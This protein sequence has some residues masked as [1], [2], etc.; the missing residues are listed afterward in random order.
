MSKYEILNIQVMR[1]KEITTNDELSRNP[2]TGYEKC[3]LKKH[4]KMLMLGLKRSQI[5][6][7]SLTPLC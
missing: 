4:F 3:M 2:G 7:N 6:V 5:S 1:T